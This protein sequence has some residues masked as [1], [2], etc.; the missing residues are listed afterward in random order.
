MLHL[1][2]AGFESFSVRVNGGL[3]PLLPRGTAHHFW[4]SVLLADKSFFVMAVSSFL[5][6]SHVCLSNVRCTQ[7]Q[8]KASMASFTSP[9]LIS[10]PAVSSHRLHS[11]QK[12]SWAGRQALCNCGTAEPSSTCQLW[13]VS[14]QKGKARGDVLL[15]LLVHMCIVYTAAL[16][17]CYI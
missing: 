15:Q 11:G 5:K 17:V 2:V 13:K 12:R 4:N 6:M 16:K 3:W 14:H 1:L 10:V 8:G 9:S 7:G